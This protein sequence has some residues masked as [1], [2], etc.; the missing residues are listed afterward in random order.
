MAEVDGAARGGLELSEGAP[1]HY[2]AVI[3]GELD[4]ESVTRLNDRVDQLLASPVSRLR[5][6]LSD[7]EFMDSSGLGLLLRLT[8]QFGPAPVHGARPLI[9]RVIE[10][11]GLTGV[12]QLEPEA[13]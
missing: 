2:T 8:N 5:F 9:R 13:P 1:G 10:V 7:L 4:I 6:D 3:F 11:S 12:L